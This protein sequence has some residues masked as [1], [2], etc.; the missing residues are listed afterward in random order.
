MKDLIRKILKENE[1]D[2]VNEIGFSKPEQFLFNKF[3][4]CKL[5]KIGS[6]KWEGWTRY[7][8]KNGK[9]LFLDNIDTGTKAPVLYFDDD[10]IYLKLKKMGLYYDE[11]KK[12]CIDMLYETHKRKVLTAMCTVAG[13]IYLLYETH[14]RKVLTACTHCYGK[15]QELYETHKRKV[16]TALGG[17]CGRYSWLYETHKRKVY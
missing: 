5:E 9:I 8:D 17:L 6:K 7:V 2:W 12:L 13:S 11:M 1:F 14:K 4:E 15:Y 3:M 10:E 16:L